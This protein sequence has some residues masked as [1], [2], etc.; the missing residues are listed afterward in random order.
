MMTQRAFS[1]RLHLPFDILPAMKMVNVTKNTGG[2]TRFLLYLYSSN[3][4]CEN[5]AFHFGV[6]VLYSLT[7]CI[8]QNISPPYLLVVKVSAVER[9]KVG[10]P[11]GMLELKGV[12]FRMNALPLLLLTFRILGF[13]H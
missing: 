8:S 11:D 13:A 2:K 12:I 6:I 7:T 3:T 1:V 4:R 10:F 5:T 9:A